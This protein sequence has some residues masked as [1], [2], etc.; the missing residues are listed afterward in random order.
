LLFTSQLKART[1]RINRG[2]TGGIGGGRGGGG[3][4]GWEVGL[5]EG[6]LETG[7][8]ETARLAIVR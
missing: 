7:Q 6:G 2:R 1:E 4:G 5:L 3:E 8:K